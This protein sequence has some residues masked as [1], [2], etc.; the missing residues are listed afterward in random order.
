MHSYTQKNMTS[1]GD[2]AKEQGIASIL[3]SLSTISDSGSGDEDRRKIIENLVR[4]VS[5]SDHGEEKHSSQKVYLETILKARK[6]YFP[7]PRGDFIDV[8][9]ALLSGGLT[10]SS[11]LRDLTGRVPSGWSDKLG[12]SLTLFV[13]LSETKPLNNLLLVGVHSP[14]VDKKYLSD[15]LTPPSQFYRVSNADTLQAL[16]T[17]SPSMTPLFTSESSFDSF[18]N[19]TAKYNSLLL[20]DT[21]RT[22]AEKHFSVVGNAA[23]NSTTTT[24]YELYRTSAKFSL[25]ERA[26]EPDFTDEQL[27]QLPILE[28][29]DSYVHYSNLH[30][31]SSMQSVS[32][33]ATLWL[34]RSGRHFLE[35]FRKSVSQKKAL[36]DTDLVSIPLTAL[37]IAPSLVKAA[38]LDNSATA[39]RSTED[40]WFNFF[41]KGNK[42]FCT[43]SDIIPSAGKT[44][45]QKYLVY[46]SPGAYSQVE[47]MPTVPK[48]STASQYKSLVLQEERMKD[49]TRPGQSGLF[50]K[51]ALNS[52]MW[53]LSRVR[54][55]LGEY[56]IVSDEGTNLLLGS[57]SDIGRLYVECVDEALRAAHPV[58]CTTAQIADQVL[59][60]ACIRIY[61][62]LS[63][64]QANT[65]GS[66]EQ[67]YIHARYIKALSAPISQKNKLLACTQMRSIVFSLYND[68]AALSVYQGDAYCKTV[69]LMTSANWIMHNL[70]YSQKSNLR[71]SCT[72]QDPSL[73]TLESFSLFANNANSAVSGEASSAF[74]VFSK[75]EFVGD[76]HTYIS[77]D[78]TTKVTYGELVRLTKTE[79]LLSLYALDDVS[80]RIEISGGVETT[81]KV[82]HDDAEY[83][84]EPIVYSSDEE[85]YGENDDDERTSEDRSAQMQNDPAVEDND[86]F[87]D[88][89]QL[90]VV[91]TQ[92]SIPSKNLTDVSIDVDYLDLDLFG[93]DLFGY[94]EDAFLLTEKQQMLVDEAEKSIP[95]AFAEILQELEDSPQLASSQETIS[96]QQQPATQHLSYDETDEDPN[97]TLVLQPGTEEPYSVELTADVVDRTLSNNLTVPFIVNSHRDD[98]P[99]MEELK[100][101][102]NIRDLVQDS[103]VMFGDV[104]LHLSNAGE[105]MRKLALLLNPDSDT[106]SP[107]LDFGT[108]VGNALSQW[109]GNRAWLKANGFV[110]TRLFSLSTGGNRG[111]AQRIV[112]ALNDSSNGFTKSMYICARTPREVGTN[113]AASLQREMYNYDHEKF[114]AHDILL[115]TWLLSLNYAHNGFEFMNILQGYYTKGYGTKN[116]RSISFNFTSTSTKEARLSLGY[117][118]S[119]APIPTMCQVLQDMQ[120]LRPFSSP[121]PVAGHSLL[122]T[123]YRRILDFGCTFSNAYAERVLRVAR[124][125][126]EDDKYVH[127]RKT[128]MADIA[129]GYE[130]ALVGYAEGGFCEHSFSSRNM[131]GE[132]Y[133]WPPV[134]A[135]L[136]W[137]WKVLSALK[138]KQELD[139]ERDSTLDIEKSNQELKEISEK[140]SSK[141][142]TTAQRKKAVAQ[143][144]RPIRKF[145]QKVHNEQLEVALKNEE[146]KKKDHIATMPP[147]IAA[148]LLSM[149]LF[150]LCEPKE[151]GGRVTHKISRRMVHPY[152]FYA[153]IAAYVTEDSAILENRSI[154]VKKLQKTLGTTLRD[155]HVPLSSIS[156][157][158]VLKNVATA[159]FPLHR[160]ISSMFFETHPQLVVGLKDFYEYPQSP[161]N[162]E[163]VVHA[164]Y[165]TERSIAAK[166]V[167]GFLA[168][169]VSFFVGEN[170]AGVGMNQLIPNGHYTWM[171]KEKVIHNEEDDGQHRWF[172]YDTRRWSNKLRYVIYTDS[173]YEANARFEFYDPVE[174]EETFPDRTPMNR[175]QA[176]TPTR[177]IE[178]AKTIPFWR[179][180][181]QKQVKPG[182]IIKVFQPKDSADLALLEILRR[183]ELTGKGRSFTV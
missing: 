99:G 133:T 48:A 114:T 117:R 22:I 155:V 101:E 129:L 164:L 163:S 26:L 162:K 20:F 34:L 63:R 141:I 137:N 40:V 92:S 142:F 59:F 111:R 110:L 179:L 8:Q 134:A 115:L 87:E 6:D 135:I 73:T 39:P 9:S 42:L 4:D 174:G 43:Y 149:S 154:V 36:S 31:S 145:S 45:S 72:I 147:M 50:T 54:G 27:E 125:Y 121:H 49:Y 81:Q 82:V 46:V 52:F 170:I 15:P 180:V 47:K 175:H 143:T 60:L 69:Q 57:F 122:S 68:F 167:L 93:G 126:K 62:V 71:F 90:D 103:V 58:L 89:H 160:N 66:D 173:E 97:L 150:S 105:S 181:T 159:P 116:K 183:E 98:F 16:W 138:Q 1:Y 94:T 123:S 169:Q 168:A 151:R 144:I 176:A 7:T 37:G 56:D 182:E 18:H 14:T 136:Y 171:S 2:Y 118:F 5:R 61:L 29:V 158:T 51:T 70:S 177:E 157:F 13:L 12:N 11:L 131:Q 95:D 38:R 139:V 80:P 124:S 32:S 120:S 74:R 3:L 35:E 166:T 119:F 88:Q 67:K 10:L 23:Q 106:Q 113:E 102:K 84:F 77:D 44:A 128:M 165:V 33:I 104:V 156:K 19:T 17:P 108:G 25:V 85:E 79:N 83:D 21:T 91:A 24:L 107:N 100:Y 146:K 28:N 172:V 112:S 161:S 152:E 76:E 96:M 153:P 109:L 53:N 148:L 75:R 132:R 30:T 86:F 127:L 78:N 130:E 55:K 41:L 65:L 140:V 178:L 64:E